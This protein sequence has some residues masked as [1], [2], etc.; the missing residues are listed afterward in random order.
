MNGDNNLEP[1]AIDDINEMERA[2]ETFIKGFELRLK[3][4]NTDDPL[5]WRE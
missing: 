5:A 4:K 2:V 3:G 1:N